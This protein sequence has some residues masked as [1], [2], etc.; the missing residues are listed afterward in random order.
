M[1]LLA[2]Q[3]GKRTR[4]KIQRKSAELREQT[5]DTVEDS[6]AQARAKAG[7]IKDDVREKPDE[8]EQRAQG[9]SMSKASACLRPSRPAQTSRPA[10]K[11]LATS[12][13]NYVWNCRSRRER[14]G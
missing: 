13:A 8:L 7:K 6:L 3:S 12:E 14:E 1:L 11:R 5:P 10:Q 4:A 9:C 2:P